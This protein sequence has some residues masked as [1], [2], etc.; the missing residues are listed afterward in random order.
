[1]R[2]LQFI[3]A[4]EG[5]E[6]DEDAA[7]EAVRM[8]DQPLQVADVVARR[9]ASAEGRAA[10]VDGVGAMVDGLDADIRIARG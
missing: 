5:V 6:R 9:G 8:R 7:A 3:V 4:Q 10:D 2:G 1:L